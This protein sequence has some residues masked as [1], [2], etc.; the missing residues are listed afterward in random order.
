MQKIGGEFV[1]QVN[2]DV[3]GN[4]VQNNVCW[5]LEEG[6]LAAAGWNYDYDDPD[7]YVEASSRGYSTTYGGYEYYHDFP[8][9]N[10]MIICNAT[11][12]AGNVSNNSNISHTINVP[13]SGDG[14]GSGSGNGYSS[15]GY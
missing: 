14:N 7:W 11:D 15:P 3:D 13:S 5:V 1:V 9:G 8:I 6:R 12:A 10:N 4:Q 2:D